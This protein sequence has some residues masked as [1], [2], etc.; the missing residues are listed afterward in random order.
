MNCDKE[1][2]QDK[3]KLVSGGGH[4]WSGERRVQQSHLTARD[5]DRLL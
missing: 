1:S 4:G 2:K 5:T 3:Q